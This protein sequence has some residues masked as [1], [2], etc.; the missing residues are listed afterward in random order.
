MDLWSFWQP[1]MKCAIARVECLCLWRKNVF[2]PFCLPCKMMTTLNLCTCRWAQQSKRYVGWTNCTN[3]SKQCSI[4]TG[5]SDTN[6]NNIS[7]R[8]IFTVL[9]SM[10]KCHMRDFTLVLQ[11]KIGQY[12]VAT[13]RNPIFESASR[14]LLG[15]TFTHRHLYYYWATRLIPIYQ[16]SEG[17]RLSRPMHCSKCAACAHAAYR[18]G[19][20]EKKNNCLQ[21]G[22]NPVT[23]RDTIRH[24][25][26]YTTETFTNCKCQWHSS[27]GIHNRTESMQI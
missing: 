16:P 11:M 3:A 25:N 24:A 14:L 26:H 2:L 15:K 22:F 8:K 4:G 17:G 6:N 12:Q 13:R 1:V 5:S 10:A 18:S 19:F 23:S 7:M 27:N 21:P 20:H 9:S